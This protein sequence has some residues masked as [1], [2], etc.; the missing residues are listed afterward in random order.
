[1][2][3]PRSR[4]TQTLSA[5]LHWRLN[6]Y[7]L[8]A[9]ATG[10]AM[11]A[12]APPSLA[13]IVYTPASGKVSRNGSFELDLNRDGIVDF[14]IVDHVEGTAIQFLSVIPA[15]GNHVMCSW[16][17]CTSGFS[18]AGAMQFGNK[19]GTNQYG[20]IDWP[21]DLMAFEVFSSRGGESFG[22]WAHVFE[23][24]ARYLGLQIQINGE[25]HFGW[26]RL[27]VRFRLDSPPT[28]E[29]RITGYAYETTPGRPIRAGQT[30]ENDEDAAR[31]NASPI[32]LA[33]ASLR[34]QPA[35]APTRFATLGALALGVDGM[36]LWRREE[37]LHGGC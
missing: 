34:R 7:A 2:R 3:S 9:G 37:L 21:R 8:A 36:A 32:H 17:A 5:P 18:Y 24:H 20:W 33:S 19:I 29:A 4:K 12:L 11:L 1:M 23:N 26:A 25:T 15:E 10:A 14:T 30:T 28:W 16:V 31:P 27:N 13:E 22:A 35:S 6:A